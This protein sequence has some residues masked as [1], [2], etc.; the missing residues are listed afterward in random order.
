MKILVVGGTGTVGSEVVRQLMGRGE[1]VFVLTRS[2]EHASKLPTGVTGVIGD[3]L[4]PS[5]LGVFSGMEAVF[6]L[7][8]VSTTESFEGL[9]GV[10]GARDAGV[11]RIVYMS[12]HHLDRAPHL[13]HFGGKIGTEAAVMKS[14][15][16]Y[17]LLR[18]N[19]FYQNDVNFRDAI[20][21]HGVYPQPIGNTGISNVDVRDVAEVAVAALTTGAH[22]KK[23]YNVVGP[24]VMTGDSMAAE[25]SRALGKPVRYA[26]DDLE[27]WEAQFR[28]YLPAAMLYDFKHMYAFFQKDG[29]K[30]TPADLAQLT[31]VLGHPPRAFAAYADEMAAAWM[32][33]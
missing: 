25:W 21:T 2:R 7:N 13:P 24:Q 18:P 26:G 32:S 1:Q 19:N 14:G 33:S 11:K 3:L 27:A 31:S 4:D 28:A 29:F 20:L 30:A 10:S 5:T 6:L 17:T 9:L 8:P 23:I 15:M 12:V 16:E 22:N